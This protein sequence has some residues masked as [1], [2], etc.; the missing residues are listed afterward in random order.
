MP[1][2]VSSTPGQS[3]KAATPTPKKIAPA[4]ARRTTFSV[5]PRDMRVLG[6]ILGGAFAGILLLVFVPSFVRRHKAPAESAPVETVAVQPAPVQPVPV[7]TPPSPEFPGMKLSSD[8]ATGKVTFD[9]QP[10]IDL[11]DAQWALDKIPAG[12]HTLKFESG[13]GSVTVALTSSAGALPAI[14]PPIIAKKILAVVVSSMG[15]HVH[16]YSSDATAKLNLDGQPSIDLSPEGAD[17]S[18]VAAGPHELTVIHGGEQYKLAIEVAPA[19]A[20]TAFVES[21]Q[22]VGTLVVVTGQDK[23]L[24]FLNG[25]AL[26]Q[27]TKGGQLRIANLDPR[28]YTV[29]VEKA[30]FQDVPEQKIRIR[31]GEQGRLVF[32]LLPVPHMASLSIQGGPP[33]ATV[34]IDQANA[35]TVQPDGT[36]TLSSIAPGDHVIELRKDRFKPRQIRKHFVGGTPVTLATSEVVLEA[37]PGELKIVFSP[38]DAQVTLTKGSEPPVKVNSSSPLN[39]PTGAYTLTARTAD[40]FV[41]TS[42]LDLTAGQSRTIDLALAPSG[43]SKWADP[44]GWTQENG[45]FVRK[46]GDYVLYGIAPTS[47]TFMF[48]AMLTKGHRLQWVLN[49][50]DPSN[51]DLF[52]MDDNNFYRTDIRNGQKVSDAKIPHKGEKKSFRTLQIHV[53]STEIVHQIK[54]GNSWFVLDRWTQPGTNLSAGRFGF[55]L[56][57]GDQMSLESFSHYLDLN[58]H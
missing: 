38:A 56:P 42:T 39:L 57:G 6:G 32:G 17:L 31:K 8:T 41:R 36:L 19:P 9:D 50:T 43:M 23:S 27:A 5:N 49:Y 52:Q 22:N 51:Y 55:Y 16:V 1:P 11:Q 28:E 12:D 7:I 58:V 21:G 34:L 10:P 53:S 26:P 37:A 33:G 24:V 3:A 14:N 54:Q 18:P 30:G 44:S 46:G 40:N 29:R 47:G 35:G 15:D 25:K 4:P 20:L 2:L 48:S 13:S 45:A